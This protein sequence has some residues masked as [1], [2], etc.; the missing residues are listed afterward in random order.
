MEEYKERK[1][2]GLGYGLSVTRDTMKDEHAFINIQNKHVEVEEIPEEVENKAY[3]DIFL[4]EIILGDSVLYQLSLN[5]ID[6]P[7]AHPELIDWNQPSVVYIDKFSTEHVLLI[8][9]GANTLHKK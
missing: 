2:K 8:F 1:K 3:D 5:P 6:L 9:M 7:L 4:D